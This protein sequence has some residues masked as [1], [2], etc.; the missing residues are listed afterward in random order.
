LTTGLITEFPLPDGRSAI[1]LAW[2]PDGSQI[3]YLLGGEP[4]NPYGGLPITG[5]VGV[6]DVHTGTAEALP[7]G[8][9]VRTAAF[10]P[11]GSE[12]A[13]Q[14]GALAGTLEV[15]SLVG[16]SRRVIQAP[17]RVLAG[18]AAWSSDGLL[19]ATTEADTCPRG[20]RSPCGADR[21]DISFVDA[22]GQGRR[23][24]DPLHVDILANDVNA[25]NSNGVLG[26]TA[27]DEI[28]VR[29][30]YSHTDAG[31]YPGWVRMIPLDGGESRKLSAIPESSNFGVGRFQLASALLPDLEVRAASDIDRGRWPLPV[32]IAVVLLTT[33]AA[34]AMARLTQ[35][36]P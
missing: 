7:G 20:D 32:R 31:L 3:A 2:S 34:A 22:T 21:D 13:L 15:V 10:S 25:L 36:E 4:T 27:P 18:P 12:L 29:A 11:E 9:N 5:D 30:G 35:A 6:L 23:V 19:L 24:P 28:V 16:D 26:W 14:H 8:S 17:G 1:P 33:I